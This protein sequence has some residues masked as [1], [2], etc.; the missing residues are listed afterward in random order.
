MYVDSC[1]HQVIYFFKY[2]KRQEMLSTNQIEI[3]KTKNKQTVVE[4]ENLTD[5]GEMGKYFKEI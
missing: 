1:N 2:A 3:S 4:R 5:F